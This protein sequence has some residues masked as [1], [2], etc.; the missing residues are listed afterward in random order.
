MVT[1]CSLPRSHNWTHIE[2]GQ[3]LLHLDHS[4]GLMPSAAGT[5]Q[6]LMRHGPG[7]H[8]SRHLSQ[9]QPGPIFGWLGE[10]RSG[11]FVSIQG[12]SE[13]PCGS[14]AQ[15][16]TGSSLTYDHTTGQLGPPPN[17]A[18][19]TSFWGVSPSISLSPAH[20]SVSRG[21]CL[22]QW[23]AMISDCRSIGYSPGNSYLACL[24]RSLP[25][26]LPLPHLPSGLLHLGIGI[27]TYLVSQTRNMG[28]SLIQLFL[29]L[30]IIQS[31]ISPL[32]ALRSL[33]LCPFQ[34]PAT[35]VP[36]LDS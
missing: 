20:Q 33:S 13:D 36:C 12:N 11:P 4:S 19:L 9:R 25:P 18:F 22:A 31:I 6:L 29:H 34:W 17:P 15:R 27:I 2:R 5:V 30:L 32:A 14:R 35:T 10:R 3:G 21:R 8:P 7:P 1:V 23:A 16:G 26:S 28:V 24:R